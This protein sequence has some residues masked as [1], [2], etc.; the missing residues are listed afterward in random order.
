[1]KRPLPCFRRSSA[2]P[3]FIASWDSFVEGEGAAIAAAATINNTRIR[4]ICASLNRRTAGSNA[5]DQSRQRR[6]SAEQSRVQRKLA[7]M[8]LLV[9]DAVVHPRQASPSLS[10]EPTD[11][12]QH[13]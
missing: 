10:V 8:V 13:M 1:R 3:G 6:H 7:A 5:Q 4:F 2:S 9:G 11:E 12:L